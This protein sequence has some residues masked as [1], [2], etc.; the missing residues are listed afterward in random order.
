MPIAIFANMI[1][2]KIM[3]GVFDR[4]HIN[5]LG[6]QMRDNFF[7]KRCLSRPR[8]TGKAKNSAMPPGIDGA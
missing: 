5:S 6:G 3:M 1:G 8:P 7:D 2:F 4:C